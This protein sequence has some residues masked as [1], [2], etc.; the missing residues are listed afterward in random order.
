MSACPNCGAMQPNDHRFC[1][2]CGQRF[3]SDHVL[4]RDNVPAP[5]NVLGSMLVAES[6]VRASHKVAIAFAAFVVLAV[7]AG[8]GWLIASSDGDHIEG[9]GTAAAVSTTP[10]P[11][12]S[13]SA[14]HPPRATT[15]A[16]AAQARS[17]DAL[18]DESSRSRKVITPE[19]AA[20]TK[21]C[22]T[23]DPAAAARHLQTAIHD[24]TDIVRQLPALP[25]AAIPNG[26]ALRQRL[27]RAMTASADAD[28]SYL[29]WVRLLVSSHCKT[30]DRS[31][32]IA[33]NSISVRQA[34]PAKRAF[35][36]LWNSVAQKYGLPPRAGSDL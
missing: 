32:L 7:V 34:T 21:G 4:G 5:D 10:A 16:A 19:L 6:P 26:P 25:M 9:A 27:A 33:G 30:T 20:L 18:L 1:T 28:R 35:V 8:A 23:V 13:R 12:P 14:S 11:R 36:S 24:R 17:V 31:G 2:T 15:A 29:Q 22:D 3:G